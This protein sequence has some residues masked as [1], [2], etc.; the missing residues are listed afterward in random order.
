MLDALLA[1]PHCAQ[2]RDSEHRQCRTDLPFDMEL[3]MD[4]QDVPEEPYVEMKHLDATVNHWGQLKLFLGEVDFLLPY[5]DV[6]KL[7]VVY[8]GASPG[9]HLHALGRAM[10]PTWTWELYDDKPNEVFSP[11]NRELVMEKQ[12]R[13]LNCVATHDCLYKQQQEL[14]RKRTECRETLGRLE[15]CQQHG[16]LKSQLWKLEHTALIYRQHNRN[17]K[18]HQQILT[19]EEARH[20]REHYVREPQ[21]QQNPQLLFISDIRTP[22]D[23]ITEDIVEWDMRVQK[24]LAR[25]LRPFQSSLKF[26][27]PYSDGYCVQRPYLDGKLLYQPFSPKVSHECRLHVGHECCKRHYDRVEFNSK[28]F[29]FQTVLR[30]SVYDNG[31][32]LPSADRHPHLVSKRVGTDHCFDCTA[33]RTIARQYAGHYGLHEL[34]VLDGWVGSLAATQKQCWA[35]G[36]IQDD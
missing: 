6:P 30:T 26:R 2:A 12:V 14:C 34:D 21:T 13:H 27:L 23:R 31:D 18:T 9:H 1:N 5:L 11:N 28:M 33:A 15:G 24:A 22:K 35:D 8:A 3:R 32:E 29:R 25:A 17:V 36:S 10:P 4:G 19:L 7:C 20:L 16:K